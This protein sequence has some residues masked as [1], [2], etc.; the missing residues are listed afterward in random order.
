M[1]FQL[2]L[3][4]IPADASPRARNLLATACFGLKPDISTGWWP[5]SLPQGYGWEKLM[6]PGFPAD[7][8]VPLALLEWKKTGLGF[9]K[10]WPVRRRV[11]QPSAVSLWQYFASDRRAA[12]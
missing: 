2:H 10:A 4:T 3:L 5:Q 12:S 8:E 9:I 7:R 11:E 6:P 1:K